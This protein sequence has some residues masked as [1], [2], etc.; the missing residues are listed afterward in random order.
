M[1][2]TTIGSLFAILLCPLIIDALSYVRQWVPNLGV[3]TNFCHP[4]VCL[5]PPSWRIRQSSRNCIN[6]QGK[7]VVVMNN[8]RSL[9]FFLFEPFSASSVHT[10]KL[11]SLTQQEKLSTP[12]PLQP[13]RRASWRLA[14]EFSSRALVMNCVSKTEGSFSAKLSCDESL[15]A[16]ICLL[17][18]WKVF[19]ALP[20]CRLI[21]SLP[22]D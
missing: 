8:R 7:S 4:V 16:S 11:F 21:C 5:P 9:C 17:D 22:L 18:S 20:H 19:R 6:K 10:R 13:F 12:M 15:Y 14:Q 1:K 2:L 3:F